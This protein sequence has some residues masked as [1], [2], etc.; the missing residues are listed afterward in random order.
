MDQLQSL[1]RERTT[2]SPGEDQDRLTSAVVDAA[3]EDGGEMVEDSREADVERV[4]VS[5]I[6][7]AD[8][9]VAGAGCCCANKYRHRS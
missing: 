5:R 9:A 2:E 4:G 8:G 7:A 3:M 1:V 6:E